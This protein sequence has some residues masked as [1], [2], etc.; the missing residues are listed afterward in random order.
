MLSNPARVRTLVY[1]IDS[2]SRNFDNELE[3]NSSPTDFTYRF[4]QPLKNVISL[5]L[6]SIEFPNTP[7]NFINQ[8]FFISYFDNDNNK[9]VCQINIPDGNWTTAEMKGYFNTKVFISSKGLGGF[10]FDVDT[11]AYKIIILNTSQVPF[12]MT[13]ADTDKPPGPREWYKNFG[14]LSGFR[15]TRYSGNF[16]Y[17]SE[18]GPDYTGCDY[19]FMRLNDY[20]VVTHQT[21]DQNIVNAFAKIIIGGERNS[22]TYDDGSNFLTK[23]IKFS[24]PTTIS[25]LN[26]KLVDEFGDV[27]DIIGHNFSFTLE[28]VHIMSSD[29]YEKYS[30]QGIPC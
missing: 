30:K 8:K 13:F 5:K 3:I 17:M 6:S 10:Q 27:L 15:K 14:Y 2:R 11:N 22:I 9:V 23:E 12:E 29:L 21:P 28:M 16:K 18:A 4:A 7:Y 1:N 25:K 26:V 20:H 19:V 24:Q